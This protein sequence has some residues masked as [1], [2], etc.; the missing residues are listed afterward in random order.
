[1]LFRVAVPL[2]ALCALA[3]P[4]TAADYPDHA[5]RLIVPFAPGGGTDVLARIVADNL[6][7][8]WGQPV[9]VENQAGASGAIGTRA[10]MKAPAD[11]YTLLM[12]STGALMAVSANADGDGPFDVN[13]YLSP[14]VI[15]AAPPY[16]LVANPNLPVKTTAELIRYAKEKPE[17]LTY[18]SSGIGAASHLSGLLFASATGIKLLHIPYKGTEPA[19]TDLLG[20]RIDIMF[21]PGP[22]VQQF[23]Q[24]GQLK[25]LGVTDTQRSKFYPDVP[26]VA[27]AVPGYESVGWFGLLAPPKTPPEIVKKINEVIVAAMQTQEF[28]DH[29]ATLGAE[30]KPQTPEEFGRYINADVAKWTK[31]VKDNNVQLP[32]GK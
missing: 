9:I 28:R 19:V 18:G 32:G 15:G 4:V 22:V 13:K 29:L 10:A 24:S 6:H 16:L 5:I 7:K 30:P 31:L 1:M 25:A 3:S 27:D 8:K 20:G 11:G 12:A 21:A 17:G 2:L 14:I 26:T 23:V